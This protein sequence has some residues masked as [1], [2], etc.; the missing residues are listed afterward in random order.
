MRSNA[1]LNFPDELPAAAT[2]APLQ[3]PVLGEAGSAALGSLAA[4]E[5]AF[6]PSH[7]TG[8]TV[9]VE[10]AGSPLQVS[11][12]LAG[13]SAG[14]VAVPL[15]AQGLFSSVG[16]ESDRECGVGVPP[17]AREAVRHA[18][19]PMGAVAA[20]PQSALAAGAAQA[21]GGQGAAGHAAQ[22]GAGPQPRAG[23][24]PRRADSFDVD[25]E[26]EAMVAALGLSK[27]TGPDAAATQ[28][29]ASAAQ[30]PATGAAPPQ[31]CQGADRT[32]A[33]AAPADKG[34]VWLYDWSRVSGPGYPPDRLL[35]WACPLALWREVR[36]VQ[37]LLGSTLPGRL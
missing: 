2:A 8:C 15:A 29:G 23:R 28:P 27:A 14:A 10:P 17:T 6:R 31:P 35:P 1:V 12:A 36:R 7:A 5:A 11:T 3:A 37:A 21:A 13:P 22:T 32:S 26:W 34:A 16:P 24:P 25:A 20:V 30:L 18:G 9:P 19:H 33:D 4:A